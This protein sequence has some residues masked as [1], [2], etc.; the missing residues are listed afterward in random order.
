MVQPGIYLGSSEMW[1]QILSLLLAILA[2]PGKVG[3]ASIFSDIKKMLANL[4]LYT[5]SIVLE[6][7]KMV[8]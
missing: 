1:I 5:C 6:R 4:S 2:M 3:I 8:I 7:N